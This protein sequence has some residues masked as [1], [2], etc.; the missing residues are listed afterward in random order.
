MEEQEQEATSL[1]LRE[2]R[3]EGKKAYYTT[4]LIQMNNLFFHCIAIR[5]GSFKLWKD[6]YFTI[7]ISKT[8]SFILDINR[9]RNHSKESLTVPY[10]HRTSTFHS[11]ISLPR[12][13]DLSL[14]RKDLCPKHEIKF[15]LVSGAIKTI[16]EEEGEAVRHTHTHTLLILVQWT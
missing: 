14:K 1:F 5:F 8:S 16:L 3:R 4:K 15:M 11:F 2:K 7:L 6:C 12:K 10:H 9:V 13:T